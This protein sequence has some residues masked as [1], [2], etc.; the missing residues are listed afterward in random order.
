MNIPSLNEMNELLDQIEENE[1]KFDDDKKNDGINE[2]ALMETIKYFAKTFQHLNHD[3]FNVLDY[4]HIHGG[5]PRD[6]IT[7]KPI[8]DIDIIID[9]R[10]IQLH[11]N[12]C[13]KYN[14]IL[15]QYLKQNRNEYNRISQIQNDEKQITEYLTSN[16]IINCLY[17]VNILKKDKNTNKNS[18]IQEIKEISKSDRMKL[19]QIFFNN[20]ID[21]D[22]IDCSFLGSSRQYFGD[23]TNKNNNT[24]WPYT[25]DDHVSRVDATFN[26][27]SIVISDIINVPLNK[28][29]NYIFD[30]FNENNRLGK[31]AETNNHKNAI[32]SLLNR[33]LVIYA[34]K[35]P[36]D[37][38][39]VLYSMDKTE[40][41][42]ELMIYRTIKNCTKFSGNVDTDKIYIDE[43]LILG[44]WMNYPKLYKTLTSNYLNR[45]VR[46]IFA[47][48]YFKKSSRITENLILN[49][50]RITLFDRHIINIYK[51]VKGAKKLFDNEIKKNNKE[52]FWN[53]MLKNCESNLNDYFIDIEIEKNITFPFPKYLN[54]VPEYSGN[55]IIWAT[56]PHEFKITLGEMYFLNFKNVYL[57]NSN[58]SNL[59][60]YYI[61]QF[62]N[63]SAY[64]VE[65]IFR[66]CNGNWKQYYDITNDNKCTHGLKANKV[67]GGSYIIY[68]CDGCNRTNLKS[69]ENIFSCKLCDYDLCE[70]CYQNR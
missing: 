32:N 58:N 16:K 61:N 26:G 24:L 9:N 40:G 12:K 54:S 47:H 30:P 2:Y 42:V 60:K 52:K 5:T 21:F 25:Y 18:I 37:V 55:L 10:S 53:K 4:F 68:D 45:F 67:P 34:G 70:K 36:Y 48:N 49:I 57:S 50:F 64:Q 38:P 62:V 44:F 59:Q 39:F 23:T 3:N 46:H 27:L 56:K 43:E 20:C 35:S 19:Y 15:S 11:A 33:K 66:G 29:K 7:G 6:V 13:N 14:C 51:T 69:G 22:M 17:F 31:F 41:Y 63:L 65:A 1:N 28:W 8:K